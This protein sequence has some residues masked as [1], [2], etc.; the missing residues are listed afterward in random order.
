M[1]KS[2]P[3]EKSR[4]EEEGGGEV[5]VRWACGCLIPA[6]F[7]VA[8]NVWEAEAVLLFDGSVRFLYDIKSIVSFGKH[9]YFK[10]LFKREAVMLEA[11]LKIMHGRS[12][13]PSG[14]TRPSPL[15]RIYSEK[16]YP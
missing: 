3:Q 15:A 7:F 2:A 13:G 9:T 6:G 4:A 1:S 16:L 5:D 14:P 8:C 11:C 10:K 12:G